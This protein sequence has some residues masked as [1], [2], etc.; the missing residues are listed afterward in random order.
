VG[1]VYDMLGMRVVVDA[2]PSRCPLPAQL[3][4][5]CYEAERIASSLWLP[6]LDR[7]K[8]YITCPKANGYQSLHLA[9]QVP[10]S[11]AALEEAGEVSSVEMQIRSAAMHVAAEH[12]DSAHFAYKGGL[13]SAQTVRLQDWTQQLMQV[14]VSRWTLPT[15]YSCLEK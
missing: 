3:E 1:E 10:R 14:T 5:A 11:L 7:R 12:G 15:L 13:D 4:A 9:V 8:D 6:V 2:A